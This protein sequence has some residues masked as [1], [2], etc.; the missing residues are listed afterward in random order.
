MYS[1]FTTIVLQKNV[2]SVKREQHL[3]TAL[4]IF[5]LQKEKESLHRLIIVEGESP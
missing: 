2:L 4:F 1:F 3:M 5:H